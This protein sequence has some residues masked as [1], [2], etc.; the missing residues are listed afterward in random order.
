MPVIAGTRVGDANRFESL[1]VFPLFTEGVPGVNYVL[2]DEAMGSGA[3]K[4]EEIGESGSVPKL[5]VDNQ[6]EALVLFLEGEELKGARQNR[7]LNASLLAPGR[8][9]TTIPVSCVEQGRWHYISR[10][11]GSSGHHSSRRLRHILRKSVTSS[12]EFDQTYGSDQGKLWRE[13]ARQSAALGTSSPTQAMSDTYGAFARRLAEFH[14]RL[15]YVEGATG[16]AVALG[17][18]VISVDLFDKAPTCRK[19]WNRLLTGMIM[20]AL[21]PVADKEPAAVAE[22]DRLLVDLRAAPWQTAPAI[23]AGEGFRAKF[24][25][26]RQ[27]TALVMNGT[28]VHGSL[29]V[30]A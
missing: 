12:T 4:V 14:E 10:H 25:D 7:I 3:V 18:R 21:E 24:A 16:L 5:M 23:G 6:T 13:V 28:L 29:L 26:D 11:L 9:L 2:A 27:A 19:I 15:K 1:T 8:S 30:P 17:K 22:V 20:E